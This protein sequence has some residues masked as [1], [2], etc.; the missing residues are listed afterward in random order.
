MIQKPFVLFSKYFKKHVC[1][2]HTRVKIYSVSG[3]LQIGGVAGILCP[4]GQALHAASPFYLDMTKA[5]ITSAFYIHGNLKDLAF[6]FVL[7]F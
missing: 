7:F 4:C 1:Y 2:F 5:G 6:F 3:E